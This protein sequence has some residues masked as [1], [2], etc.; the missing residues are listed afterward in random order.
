M[1]GNATAALAVLALSLPAWPQGPFVLGGPP[2]Q[3]VEIEAD[4]INYAWE[5]QLLKLEGHV[6]AR[7]GE[8][9][10]RAAAGTLDRAHGILTLSGGV[11]GV[12]GKDVLLADGAVI[13]LNAHTADL[14]AATLYLKDRPANPD[15]PRAGRNSLILHGARVKQLP[16]GYVAEEVRLTPCDCAGEPDYELLADTAKLEGDRARLSGAKLRFLGAAIPLFPLAL[17]LTQRQWGLLAPEFGFGAPYWFTYAQPVFIPLGQSNDLTVTPGYYTGG[18]DH[19]FDRGDRT[20]DQRQGTRSIKGPRLGLE[21]RYAPV[22]GTLG[23]LRLD[24][25]Q[26]FD[27]KDSLGQKAAYDGERG[28]SDGRGFGGLR[29]VAHLN[30]RSERD[31]AVFAVDGVAATDVMAVRDPLPYSLDSLQDM[32]RTDVGAWKA[33]P[34]FTWGADA[35]LMQDVRIDNGFF[36]DRRLFG[37][38]RRATFQRAPAAFAQLAP[39]PIGPATFEVE[40]G[41]AQFERFASAGPQERETGF[42]PTDRQTG[43]IPALPYDGSRAP[44]VRL[45]LSPRLRWTL[46][47]SMLDLRAEAGA[48]VDGYLF[49]GRAGQDRSRA[50]ALAGASAGV[51]L[52]RK[53]G[54][55]LHRI[56]PRIVVR[57]LSRPLQ[58]GGPPVGDLTDAGGETFASSPDASQQGLSGGVVVG[59]KGAERQGVPAVRRAYDEIDFAAPVSGAVEATASLSQSLWGKAGK[60][61]SRVARFD[62][63]QDFLLWAHGGKRRLGEGSAVASAQVGPVS[64]GG[65]V[66]YDWALH[67]VSAISAGANAHDARTDEVHGGLLLLRGSSSERLR[68]GIDEIFSAARYDVPPG[69]LGGSASFGASGPLPRPGL[70]LAYDVSYTPG[71]TPDSFAN[72]YHTAKLS[73]ET[74]CKCAGLL[75]IVGFPF[76]DTHLLKDRPDFSVRIDLRSLGSFGTF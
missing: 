55:L 74:A 70:R 6:V 20:R 37:A 53:F 3:E 12:Q 62:L 52:E 8:G 60:G 58:S 56:E 41:V 9:I 31:G 15:Q 72:F 11:L 29:G 71:T 26:D 28:T 63:L 38:E 59:P 36:P 25:Y 2:D 45:D 73:Y 51:P 44:M 47:E 7:R 46:P 66:R 43:S 54:S 22:E 42:A 35:T 14:K 49:E 16:A 24:L 33:S 68:A 23:T 69:D 30:H 40:A 32:L 18:T 27:A 48:R 13:D 5:Q 21:W 64:V 61:A 39:L 50:Y 75:L 76:H 17:P 4:R 1:P 57:A 67:D 19:G 65:A 10:V 34:G